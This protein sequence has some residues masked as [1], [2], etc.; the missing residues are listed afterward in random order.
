MNYVDCFSQK[1]GL[2]NHFER[3]HP[4]TETEP[5]IDNVNT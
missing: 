1:K 3:E 5:K 4:A 2:N